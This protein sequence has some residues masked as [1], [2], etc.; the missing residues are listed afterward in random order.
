MRS[1]F[2]P[3]GCANAFLTLKNKTLV[4]YY[5]TSSYSPKF[6]KIRFNDPIIKVKWPKKPSIISEKDKSWKD[7]V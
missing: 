3:K 1:L 6:E 5:C 7:F 4:H 2:V